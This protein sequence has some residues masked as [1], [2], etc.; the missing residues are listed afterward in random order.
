M[1][2]RIT[3][4]F[5][6]FW[7]GIRFS[8]SNEKQVQLQLGEKQKEKSELFRKYSL[9][10]KSIMASNFAEKQSVMKGIDTL[11][12]DWL[13][14]ITWPGYWPLFGSG[15]VKA[16]ECLSNQKIIISRKILTMLIA[17]EFHPRQDGSA[18]LPSPS[19]SSS[20]LSSQISAPGLLILRQFVSAPTIN[21]IPFSE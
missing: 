9:N 18:T 14:V 8:L 3:L 6:I 2:V 5:C 16:K 20:S 11:A 1:S 12:S 21:I 17:L 13:K 7:V 4:L 19:S 15:S 10:Q